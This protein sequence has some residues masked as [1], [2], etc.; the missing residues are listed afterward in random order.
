M[1]RHFQPSETGSEVS[2]SLGKVTA[3]PED[4]A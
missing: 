4:A 2:S 3:S 1:S